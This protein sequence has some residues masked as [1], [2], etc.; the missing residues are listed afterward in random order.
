ML[1]VVSVS[2]DYSLRSSSSMDST[3]EGQVCRLAPASLVS[4]DISA[5][6][7]EA[8]VL[9]CG[10]VNKVCGKNTEGHRAFDL[11]ERAGGL[12]GEA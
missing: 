2:V 5:N 4:L 6:L 8:S 7:K 1:S 3:T 11:L 9:L 10:F 12:P